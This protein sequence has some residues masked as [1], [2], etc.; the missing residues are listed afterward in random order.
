LRD[1]I[2]CLLFVAVDKKEV[3]EG[4]V[5]FMEKLPNLPIMKS[6]GA[7]THILKACQNLRGASKRRFSS[8]RGVLVHFPT[9]LASF[10]RH[11]TLFKHLNP[12]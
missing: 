9:G 3:A 1:G 2:F 4:M 12:V 5:F 10:R 11:Y 8:A 6:V 7:F